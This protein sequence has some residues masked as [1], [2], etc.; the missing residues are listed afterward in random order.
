VECARSVSIEKPC[1]AITLHTIGS[2][3][4]GLETWQLFARSATKMFTRSI[5]RKD[6][7]EATVQDDDIPF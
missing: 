7:V 2:I 3:E 4:N 6:P 5:R 1:S